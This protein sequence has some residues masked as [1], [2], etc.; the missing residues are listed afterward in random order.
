MTSTTSTTTTGTDCNFCPEHN[1]AATHDSPTTFNGSWAYTCDRHFTVYG[2][3]GGTLLKVETPTLTVVGKASDI[4]ERQANPDGG[5][6]AEDIAGMDIEE[7][8]EYFGDTDP[9]EYL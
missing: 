4:Y 9:S 6:V 2:K 1:G 8:F 7:M 3:P 5:S